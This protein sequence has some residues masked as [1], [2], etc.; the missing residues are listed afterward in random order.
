MEIRGISA[1]VGVAIGFAYV[2]K[3]K[4]FTSEASS[5]QS[6]NIENEI[7]RFIKG[8]DISVKQ[9]E[10]IYQDVLEKL[11]EEKAEIFQGQIEIITDE[12]LT[13][14]ITEKIKKWQINA[15]AATESVIQETIDE[16]EALEDF[17]LRAR[18]DDLRDIRQRIVNNIAGREYAVPVIGDATI[19]IGYEITPSELA[20][21]NM[22][23]IIGIVTET[24]SI[25]SH[26]AIMAQTLSIPAIV[27][28]INVVDAVTDGDLLI[29]DGIE[30]KIII[31]PSQNTLPMY[32]EKQRE[33]EYEKQVLSKYVNLPAVTQDGKH[34]ELLANIGTE[35]DIEGAIRYGADGIGLYRTEYLYMNQSCMPTEE[36]QFDAYKKVVE[37]MQGKAVIIRT[38]DLGGD[39]KLP[40]INFQKEDNPFLGWRGVRIYEDYPEMIRTQLRAILRASAYGH[41]KI[42]FPMIISIEEVLALK[43][44]IADLKSEFSSKATPFDPNI[45][46]GIMIETPAAVMISEAL[47]EEVDFFSIGTNDL[48]QYTLAVDRGNSRIAYRY[49]ALHPSI[50]RFIQHVVNNAHACGKTV[51]ICGELAS[52]PKATELLIGLGLDSLSMN[53]PCIPKVKEAIMRFSYN[54]A[55]LLAHDACRASSSVQISGIL[56]DRKA[57]SNEKN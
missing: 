49:N 37:A 17:Y 41:I 15:E 44:I 55:L 12:E 1:S 6:K 43:K 31:N 19:L 33:C 39:K 10:K 28:A 52:D 36:V 29:I 46:I 56:T 16:V 26:V 54:D 14:K 23:K 35:R 45:K 47:A 18:A 38:V 3:K 50:L 57:S 2:L 24:G 53:S 8:R 51:G 32:Q 42:M 5:I 34:I 4:Y 11:G 20:Q 30:G 25:T 40:Y 13:K 7:L 21:F 22:E 48:T 27:G 9:L